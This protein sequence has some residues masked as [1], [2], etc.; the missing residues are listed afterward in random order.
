MIPC[1]QGSR[2]GRNRGSPAPIFLERAT[3]DPNPDVRKLVRWGDRPL[4]GSMNLLAAAAVIAC[5]CGSAKA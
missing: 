3:N 1:S 5:F 4:S 2:L